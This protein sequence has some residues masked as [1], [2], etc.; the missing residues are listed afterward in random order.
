MNLYIGINVV[1]A[2]YKRHKIV[3]ADSIAGSYP[4]FAL[5]QG[6]HF[7]KRPFT[8]LYEIKGLFNMPK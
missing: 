6:V 7:L 8:G 1:E 5:T 2:F 3:F 4:D